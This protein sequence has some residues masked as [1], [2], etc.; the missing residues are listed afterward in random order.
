MSRPHQPPARICPDCLGSRVERVILGET[1]DATGPHL[2][3]A[4]RP[5][6]T[7]EGRGFLP[8]PTE[9]A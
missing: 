8:R 3:V 9:R 2:V 5:C 7:C 4:V 6:P 1:H